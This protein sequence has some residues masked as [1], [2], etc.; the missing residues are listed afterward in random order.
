[1]GWRPR[2]QHGV[3]FLDRARC[4]PT[5]MGPELTAACLLLR[6]W[7]GAEARRHLEA[8]NDILVARVVINTR[9]SE[10]ILGDFSECF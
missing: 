3:T 7:R 4:P 6:K 8:G 10:G 2:R 5:I 1:M 9:A